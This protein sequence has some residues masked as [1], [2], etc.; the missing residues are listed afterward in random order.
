MKKMTAKKTSK[1]MTKKVVVKAEPKKHVPTPPKNP[2][3]MAPKN[4]TQYTQAEF[5][6]SVRGFCGFATRKEAKNF[7]EG[8]MTMLQSNLKNGYKVALPGL[9]KMQV[10][11]TKARMGRNPMTQETIHIPARKKV[12]FTPNKA[13]KEAVL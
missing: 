7:Y 1:T 12:A 5:Y 13:M 6:E 3:L 4:R 8:F 9:G 2:T 10:R 11:R